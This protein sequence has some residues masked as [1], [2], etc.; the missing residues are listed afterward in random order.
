MT[1]TD[2]RAEKHI[3]VQRTYCK[4][5]DWYKYFEDTAG[6]ECFSTSGAGTRV[7]EDIKGDA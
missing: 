7:C 5:K 2:V 4:D 1:N 6:A 3:N